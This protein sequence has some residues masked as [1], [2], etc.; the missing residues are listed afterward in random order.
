MSCDAWDA[1]RVCAQVAQE[2]GQH[3]GRVSSLGGAEQGGVELPVRELAAQQVRRM[4][5]ERGLALPA[6][7][8][9]QDNPHRPRAAIGHGGTG[10]QFLQ[11]FHLPGPADEIGDVGR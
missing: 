4:H 6:R 3:L 7:A 10:Q 11:L 2:P 8:H 1:R 9:H 5:G